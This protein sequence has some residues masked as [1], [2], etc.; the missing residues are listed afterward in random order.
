MD[1]EG[2][3]RL[4]TSIVAGICFLLVTVM[5][6]TF[7][8]IHYQSSTWPQFYFY[9]AF[10]ALIYIAAAVS[11]VWHVRGYKVISTV[12]NLASLR[13]MVGIFSIG[14]VAAYAV[15]LVRLYRGTGLV[16]APDVTTSFVIRGLGGLFVLVHLLAATGIALRILF[17]RK[18]LPPG[19]FFVGCI[20]FALVVYLIVSLLTSML[21]VPPPHLSA[22]LEALFVI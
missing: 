19:A 20:G 5:M 1:T 6:E 3:R 9:F 4:Q 16:E 17:A 14:V 21:G 15:S 22:F 18:S 13:W 10:N 8:R 11:L 2:R 12:Y 7:F